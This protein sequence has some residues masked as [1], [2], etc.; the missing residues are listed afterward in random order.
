MQSSNIPGFLCVFCEFLSCYSSSTS[1]SWESGNL[2]HDVNSVLQA[3]IYL[4][5]VWSLLWTLW[6][7]YRNREKKGLDRL[8]GSILSLFE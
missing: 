7:L 8:L 6:S 2:F 4:W 1:V 3:R 5:T